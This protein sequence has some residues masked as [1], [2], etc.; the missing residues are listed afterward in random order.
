MRKSK[1]EVSSLQRVAMPRIEDELILPEEK[2]TTG[3]SAVCAQI[4]Q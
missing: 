3:L 1:K 2:E 4:H